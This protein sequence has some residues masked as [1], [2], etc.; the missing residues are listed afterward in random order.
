MNLTMKFSNIN[1]YAKY[2]YE[3]KKYFHKDLMEKYDF[4]LIS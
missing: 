2:Q 4:P 1:L 3:P